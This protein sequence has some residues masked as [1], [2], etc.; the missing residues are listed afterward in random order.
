MSLLDDLLADQSTTPALKAWA[1]DVE[2]RLAALPPAAEPDGWGATVVKPPAGMS[3]N[4]TPPENHHPG[5]GTV[6]VQGK[7][8]DG[9]SAIAHA[10]ISIMNWPPAP[11]LPCAILDCQ[12]HRIGASTLGSSKAGTDG[13]GVWAGQPGSY[14]RLKIRS[15]G[16]EGLWIGALCR[17]A[18]FS[19]LDID[20][21]Q[22]SVKGVG[23]YVEHAAQDCEIR[24]SH[25]IPKL[26]QNA[27]LFEWRYADAT[28]HAFDDVGDGKAGSCR[29]HVHHCLL[30]GPIF[31]DAGSYGH[32]FEHLTFRG[33]NGLRAAVTLPR[34]LPPHTPQSIVR[35]CD[36]TG[37]NG[38]S[39]AFHSNAI[40]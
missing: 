16:W 33:G 24:N 5:S 12:V 25:I 22:A 21:T 18:V 17:G 7:L 14:A 36:F 27:I 23:I 35:A 11:S 29:F 32:T 28:Y 26:G 8:I 15:S 1:A 4:A 31:V 20:E 30:E 39:V 2:R 3:A 40:G 6:T 13:A 9:Q 19:D 34:N 10:G 37:W 38:P